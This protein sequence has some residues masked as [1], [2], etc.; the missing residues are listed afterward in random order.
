[1][2]KKVN[3]VILAAG[4]GTRMR[5]SLPKVLHTLSHKTLLGHVIDTSRSVNADNICVVYGH[6][7]DQ[8][9][10]SFAGQSDIAWAEQ[11][12]QLGTGHALKVALPS[13][14]KDGVTL[15]LYGDVPLTKKETLEKLIANCNE[16]SV[17]L[18]TAKV[19]DPTGYGR[20]VRDSANKVSAIVEHKDA[21][22]EQLT[23]DEINTGILA[24]PASKIE[25]WVNSFNNDNAQGEYYLTDVIELAVNEG[26][27]VNT[28]CVDDFYETLGVNSRQQ[29]AELERYY[30]QQQAEKL[31]AAG[32]TL[33]DPARLDIRGELT[34]GQ[35]SIVDVNV[36][37]EGQ[38]E[39]GQNVNIG[40]NCI[41]KNVKIGNNTTILPNSII[42]D[43]TIGDSANIGPYARLRPGTVLAN[44]TKVGNFVE[45]KNANIAD[46][47][48][49]NHLSYVGDAEVGKDVNIGAGT[50]TCNYD[51]ANKH[52]TVIKDNSFIGSNSALVAPV[53]IAEG[54]TV[55]AGS[56]ITADTEKDSLTVARAK[57]RAIKGWKRPVKNK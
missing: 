49:V 51:G 42:E 13:I 57:Q 6:G 24:L 33:R 43:S 7:G 30:Q 10:K 39:I 23:I 41:F 8:V 32:V 34:V 20:I 36:I 16:D 26:C 1:M 47:S 56:T 12:Q 22:T 31:M 18:L 54:S 4:K 48:K 38:C 25:K 11:E 19:E 28:T 50:I 5:S 21:N 2:A 29:L 45:I 35:D 46:G 15:V 17:A 14:E 44:A 52:L 55:G 40:A 9:L 3:I 27:K 53:N 37:F